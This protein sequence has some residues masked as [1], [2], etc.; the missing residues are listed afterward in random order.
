MKFIDYVADQVEIF[1][2]MPMPRGT[3]WKDMKRPMIDL[4]IE[5][6]REK[7]NAEQAHSL[8]WSKTLAGSRVFL[9]CRNASA[10]DEAPTLPVIRTD[11]RT[12]FPP[13]ASSKSCPYCH[14]D[15]WVTGDGSFGLTAAQPCDHTGNVNQ[16]LGISLTS[17]QIDRYAQEMA[18]AEK[19]REA[20][21]KAQPRAGYRP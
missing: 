18:E 15:N 19:R 17:R 5:L 16:N 4:L 13:V 3:T 20:A 2:G 14:G 7:P 8:A 1:G 11:W 12:M 10:Y 21:F 9:I 6:S